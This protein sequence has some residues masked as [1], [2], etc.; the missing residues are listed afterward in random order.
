MPGKITIRILPTGETQA[1]TEGIRGSGCSS[2]IPRIERL[3]CAETVWSER[4]DE[5]H[6]IEERVDAVGL[7]GRRDLNVENN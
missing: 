6:D 3:L 1:C 5:Y 2:L 4:T 7:L